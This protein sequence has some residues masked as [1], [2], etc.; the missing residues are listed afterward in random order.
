MTLFYGYHSL[1]R[2][3]DF[4]RLFQLATLALAGI[5]PL[6][7]G[8]E[9]NNPSAMDQTKIQTP[10]VAGAETSV[11]SH[12]ELQTPAV[13]GPESSVDRGPAQT[14][15]TIGNQSYLFDISDHTMEE[16]E[17]LLHRAE[18]ITQV[19]SEKFDQLDIVMILHG[20]D[21]DWFREQ[22]YEKNK[23]LVDLAAKLDAFD[24]IDLKVC[25]TTMAKRGVN[26]EELPAFIE[27]VPYAPDEM[28][29]LQQEGYI[30]L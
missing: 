26:P 3:Y 25:E 1:M 11:V 14:Q 24:I 18:E 2:K 22:N 17:A 6:L 27:P 28:A 23:K 29:R 7:T 4:F 8:C 20:P 13:A 16:L 21:I 9:Q 10:A 30:N 15:F 5:I 12:A 19:E